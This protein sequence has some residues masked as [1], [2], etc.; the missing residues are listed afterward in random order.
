MQYRNFYESWGILASVDFLQ[1]VGSVLLQVDQ[2][3][4]AQEALDDVPSMQP[5]RN[6]GKTPLKEDCRMLEE[7]RKCLCM[8][9]KAKN[10]TYF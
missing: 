5:T 8:S 7:Y 6:A 1:R 10:S 9:F 2:G 4:E 3:S